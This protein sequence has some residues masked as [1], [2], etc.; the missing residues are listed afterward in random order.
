[1]RDPLAF[2][3]LRDGSFGLIDVLGVGTHP[4]ECKNL[5]GVEH[6]YWHNLYGVYMQRATAE[7]LTLRW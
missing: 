1:M 3:C 7:G 6:R 4:Q 2:P 5:E